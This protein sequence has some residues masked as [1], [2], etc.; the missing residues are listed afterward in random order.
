MRLAGQETRTVPVDEM[1]GVAGEV[2]SLVIAV[3]GDE[4]REWMGL[5]L[6]PWL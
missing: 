6:R 1:E 5:G 2:R 3:D 4:L